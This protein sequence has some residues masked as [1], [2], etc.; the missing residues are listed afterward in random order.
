MLHPHYVCWNVPSERARIEWHKSV[1]IF[2]D[3]VK[4]LGEKYHKN[5]AD[6]LAKKSTKYAEKL[7]AGTH[8]CTHTHTHTNIYS[9]GSGGGSSSTIYFPHRQN[10]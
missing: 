1:L 3:D 7:H 8:A 10:I 5:N 4:L 9:G 6:R 2:A